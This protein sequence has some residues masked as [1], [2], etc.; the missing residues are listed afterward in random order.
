M[1]RLSL[2]QRSILLPALIIAGLGAT[3]W[4]CRTDANLRFLPGRA[5]AEWIVYPNPPNLDIHPI[6]DSTA[7]FRRGFRLERAESRATLEVC[8]FRT[9]ASIAVNGEAIPPGATAPRNWKE[10]FELDLSGRL[11]AGDNEI[12]ITVANDDAPPALWAVLRSGGTE[13]RSDAAWEVSWAG[14]ALRPARLARDPM[15]A[16][17]GNPML[18]CEE[19]VESL[20]LVWPALALMAV[21]VAG[22][23]VMARRGL[24]RLPVAAPTLALSLFILMW[25]ALFANNLESLRRKE[26]FDAGTHMAYIQYLLS[27]GHVPL[28]SQGF[29]MYQPPLYYAVAAGL[30]SAL[31]LTLDSAGVHLLNQLGLWIA[32][33]NLVFVGKA[34]RLIFPGDSRKQIVGLAAAA[35]LPANLCLSQFITNEVLAATLV[36]ASLWLSLVAVRRERPGWKVFIALGVCMG[37]ALLT[38]MSAL[39]AVPFAFGPVLI[40]ACG[41]PAGERR[42]WFARL[43][44][45]AG[46]C[47]LI[48]G[49]HYGRLWVTY[50]SPL[51][52]NWNPAL[53]FRWW[54]DDG[55]RTASYYLR[56]GVALTHP[57]FGGFV[58]L[59]DGIYST[60]WG[61]GLLS[62]ATARIF[63]MPWN[64]HLMAACYL[65][66]LVP[67]LLLL[68]GCVSA[69]VRFIR[70]PRMELAVLPAYGA[71]ALAALIWMSLRV[72]SYAEV[73]SF[74]MLSALLP[75]C[76][77]TALG[78][79]LV[80]RRSRVAAAAVG[81]GVGVWALASFFS[82]WIRTDSPSA[83][84]A[85]G[86]DLWE[87]KHYAEAIESFSRAAAA[88][89]GNAPVR[90]LLAQRLE[91]LG[92]WDEALDA[93]TATEKESPRDGAAHALRASALATENRGA[94]ALVEAREAVALAPDFAP[95]HAI[96]VS[97]LQTAN[98]PGAMAQ[99]A[100]EALRVSPLDGRLH[101][102]LGLALALE[103]QSDRSGV[104]SLAD[105]A[106]G[107]LTLATALNPNSADT[108]SDLGTVLMLQGRTAEAMD[109]FREALKINPA[110][111]R[112]LQ[113]LRNF[114]PRNALR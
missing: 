3:D 8:A 45:A 32:I 15:P 93:C 86:L 56:F 2:F 51:V 92:R 57:W 101:D 28:A 59:P 105:E 31:G 60:L 17:T 33:A 82:F 38:K 90:D 114:P 39:L 111:L 66:A 108:R 94:E 103:A 97:L 54:Q 62:G 89:P 65:L 34:L 35:F 24:G 10:P 67:T 44:A 52:G 102:R 112:A 16:G 98:N 61:D 18:G 85:N 91:A 68:A 87:Q 11:R 96:L 5:P 63:R 12:A 58:S 75:M 77:L 72:P 73:K 29:E 20:K 80:T 104:S 113:N 6:V 13:V 99:A 26:G 76:V 27:H 106:C 100:R 14:A 69:A 107:Q 36:T 21:F 1:V 7:V 43:A 9:V 47:V 84:R 88:D 110:D 81:I 50:G 19:T 49:W 74:Y 22:V 30:L 42:G 41:T 79:D 53:G 64:Y 55:F 37:A 48:S 78:W 23:F 4:L 46:L 40:H 83:A 71:A 109:Q 95:G 25:V 70:L